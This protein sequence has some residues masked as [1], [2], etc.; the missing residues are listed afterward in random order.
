MMSSFFHHGRLVV[1]WSAVYLALSIFISETV[2]HDIDLNIE[3][4]VALFGFALAG[5]VL[6]IA[7]SHTRRVRLVAGTVNAATLANRQRR[8]IE[9]PFEAGE[10][11]DM[12]DR[13]KRTARLAAVRGTRP[14]LDLHR[15]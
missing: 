12:I 14:S 6:L 9:I 1:A 5:W 10:A 8:Q 3:G 13:C 7:F 2:L 4:Y 11:F 15:A